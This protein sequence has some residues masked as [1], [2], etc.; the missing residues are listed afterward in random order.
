MR[1]LEKIGCFSCVL[2]FLVVPWAGAKT[3]LITRAAGDW[4]YHDS[5]E[6]PPATWAASDFNDA[7]WKSG[8][9]PLGYDGKD[10]AT[11]L[12]YGDDT[13][14]KHHAAF[15]RKVIEVPEGSTF[16]EFHAA[17][18][19][20]DGAAL[21]LN[22]K[23]LTSFNLEAGEVTSE[24][25]AAR[26][27]SGE[28]EEIY[29]DFTLP[30]EALKAGRNVLAISLHQAAED[31]SDL[32]FDF[33]ITGL[34]EA[35][36]PPRAVLRPEAKEVVETFRTTHLVPPGTSIPDGYRDGGTYMKVKEDGTIVSTRE[37][38]AIERERDGKLREHL[39]FAKGT[40]DLPP[41]ER[42]QKI[43]RYVDELTTPPGGRALAEAAT[44]KLQE[45]RNREI[46]LGEIPGY[47]GAGVCRHRSLLFK[48]LGDEAGLEVGLRRGQALD[49]GRIIGRHAWN[50]LTL[51]DGS[52]RIV[53]VMS[54]EP[55]FRLPEA[56]EVYF[57]YGDIK[58]EPLYQKSAEKE[59]EPA[60][61][62]KKKAA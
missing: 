26:A 25:L 37:V 23:L 6:A 11:T 39:A 44:G 36:L 32:A 20:D 13:A 47:C 58:G 8:P 54:P 28:M 33:E 7:S 16:V 9:A 40:K 38:I 15:L 52:L 31:S 14:H 49:R 2:T 22:G 41:V 19:C 43:A 61:T 29:H 56:S 3:P 34:T 12:S 35:D 55:D 59:E 21:Y 60:E 1:F 30:G 17:M 62:E 18:R 42:A 27:I 24:T 10:I 50:E 5:G 48:I 53:D 46:L 45:V 4:K 51:P 57:R